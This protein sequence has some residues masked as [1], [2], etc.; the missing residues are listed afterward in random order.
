RGDG[1]PEGART[2]TRP[3]RGWAWRGSTLPGKGIAMGK[4]PVVGLIGLV[5][6]GIALTGCE[7]SRNNRNKTYPAPPPPITTPAPSNNTFPPPANTVG[8]ATNPNDR[9][10]A[11]MK[12]TD[13][14]G[15]GATGGAMP[16][17]SAGD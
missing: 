3:R 2:Q 8:G 15:V 5:W 4:K 14:S 7:S 12:P 9:G 11:P 16:A 1:W 13:S 6:A 10:F 17:S